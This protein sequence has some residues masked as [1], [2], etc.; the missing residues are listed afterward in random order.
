MQN[1][2]ATYQSWINENEALDFHLDNSRVD[3]LSSGENLSE[4]V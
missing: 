2:L 3:K 1:L 4:A